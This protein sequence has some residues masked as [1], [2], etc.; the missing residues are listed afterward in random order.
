MKRLMWVFALTSISLS[1]VLGGTHEEVIE[2]TLDLKAGGELSLE[3]VNGS[4]VVKTWDRDQVAMTATKKVKTSSN[5]QAKLDAVKIEIDESPGRITIRTVNPKKKWFGSSNK[6][7]VS[8]QLRVP[9]RVDL[10]INDTNGKIQVEDV[11]GEVRA[12]TT[13]GKVVLERIRGSFNAETTNGK[14]IVELLEHR[15]GRLRCATTNGSIRVH[16]PSDIEADL[17]ARTT[18]GSVSSDL[19][20]TIMG[21]A[22]RRKISGSINGGGVE[23]KLRT[24]NGSITIE[25]S[26]I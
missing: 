14:I 4:I 9:A 13:N 22:G 5:G 26:S 2:R 10:N 7:R 11:T 23:V 17:D 24:T 19:P 16:L 8:Y 15:G 1:I 20:I 6:V 12:E 18:N 21:S 25:K 3:N